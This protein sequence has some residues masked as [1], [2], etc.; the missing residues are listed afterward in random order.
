MY[1][2]VCWLFI[3]YLMHWNC[4][5]LSVIDG[6]GVAGVV[7]VASNLFMG[8]EKLIHVDDVFVAEPAYSYWQEPN[9]VVSCKL[10]C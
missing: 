6:L 4:T 8:R 10:H 9:L 1:V 5:R 7:C 3:E 2:S